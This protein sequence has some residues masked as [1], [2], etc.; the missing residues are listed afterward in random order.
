MAEPVPFPADKLAL[1][2]GVSRSFYL[3]IR[4][5]PAPLREPVAVAYL[6]ARAT[7]TLADTAT[8]PASE[9]LDKLTTLAAAIAGSPGSPPS[10][11]GI[12]ALMASFAPLQNDAQERQLILALPECLDW[13][14]RLAPDDRADVRTVLAH[15]THGQTLDVARFGDGTAVRALASAAEL[16]D[17]TWRVAGCVGE[18]WT[19]LGFR[20]L[21]GFASLPEARMREL[22][23]GYG[24]GLQLINILRD[25]GADLAAG[26]CY[27]PAD[28]LAAAGLAPQDITA[29]PEL[30]EPVY[31]HWLDAAQRRLAEGMAYADALGSRRVRAASAL[32]A[33]VGARTLA[34]L[35]AAGPAALTQRVKLPRH[36]MRMLLLRL[37]L[38]LA[39]RSALARHFRQLGRPA[40]P[41]PMGQSRP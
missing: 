35:R 23:R 30:F 17:Y 39:G 25:A 14:A 9:R 34:L 16:D 15:I 8:L 33:L 11:D 36:E 21:P 5:L 7:D 22:G 12:R 18:F 6:L 2:R 38:G 24:M 28:A 19:A 41:P 20:H 40:D 10:P 37:A 31:R 13:L 29:R 3:S 1:L 26:R 27:F 4:L 32:P